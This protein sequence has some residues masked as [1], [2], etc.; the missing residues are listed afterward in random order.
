MPQEANGSTGRSVFHCLFATISITI[1]DTVIL[2]GAYP[3][4]EACR[5]A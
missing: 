3:T 1:G 2:E 5:K 4:W